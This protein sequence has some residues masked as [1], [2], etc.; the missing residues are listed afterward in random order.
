MMKNKF[1]LLIV[2]LSLFLGSCAKW[3]ALQNTRDYEYKYEAA[4]SL[5]AEGKYG[6]ASMYFAEVLAIMKGTANAEESLYLAGMSNFRNKDYDA[7]SQ[8]FKK[9]YQV[10][11]K[12]LYVEYAR[13]YCGL[14]LYNMTPDPRLDQQSTFEAIK[15]F[16]EF[17]DYYPYTSIKESTQEMI[18]ALQDKL[19]EKEYLS[20]K[21]Y[22]DLGTYTMNCAYGGSNYEAC[23]VTAQNALRDFPFAKPE[24]REELSIMVLR[25][26]YLLAEQS[27]DIKRVLRYRD[28]I[29]EY[30]SFVNDFP[31]SRYVKEAEKIMS[32]STDYVTKHA[33]KDEVVE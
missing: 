29:D 27:I 10:Y 21:L 25:A 11:P 3:T 13:Y 31:E 33:S 4:K 16:Q 28:C 20:A 18:Y 1:Y 15:E 24:R 22:Y 14:S 12:G 26:K 5:Y 2:L 8:Y 17:L 6:Q 19:V 9:Y 23:V 30:Y 32:K 7:A